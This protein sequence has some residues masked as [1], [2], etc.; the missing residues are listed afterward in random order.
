MLSKSKSNHSNTLLEH[1]Y[2][3]TLLKRKLTVNSQMNSEH[4]IR[5]SGWHL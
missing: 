2:T 3:L 5:V 4:S 1:T